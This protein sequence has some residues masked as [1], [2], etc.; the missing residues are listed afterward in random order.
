[1]VKRSDAALIKACGGA[2]REAGGRTLDPRFQYMEHQAR[3]R[4]APD[5]LTPEVAR[6]QTRQLVELF[7]ARRERGVSAE[8]IAIPA[9]LVRSIPARLY[10][11]AARNTAM[12]VF[13]YYHFGG[14]VVGDLDTSDAFCSILAGALEGAVLSVDYRLA[15][16]HPWPAGL[17]DAIA[18]YRWAA[19]NPDRFGAARGRIAVGG[20]SIGGNFAA[21]VAQEMQRTDGPR[22][23]AQL[24]IYPATDLVA[25]TP[26]LA[27]YADAF[28]LTRA[29]MDFFMSHYLPH[30]QDRSDL[31]LSPA[32][33]PD[34]AG[35]PPAFIYTAGFDPLVDQGA[36][37]AQKLSSAGVETRYHCFDA[38]AHGF[39][40]FTG[41]VPA[42]DV[43]CRRMAGEVAEFLRRIG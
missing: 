27:T 25:E 28:P 20:D 42:A 33:A 13:V 34:L 43:A 37:Y 41:V 30:D 36:A 15:P 1:M 23:D 35:L 19:A 16:E 40:A 26:S 38:L 3:K 14:G 6:A 22:P 7:G 39:T 18:A 9:E 32:R 29:T 24:L 21:I 10:L 12:G 2:P 5:P 11:P 17:E 4:P 31:R 8:P